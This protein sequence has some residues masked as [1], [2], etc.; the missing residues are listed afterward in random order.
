MNPAGDI[1]Q[2]FLLDDMIPQNGGQGLY[3]DT[4]GFVDQS[5]YSVYQDAAAE[6]I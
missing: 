3:L 2:K 6:L 4:P 5:V 1:W